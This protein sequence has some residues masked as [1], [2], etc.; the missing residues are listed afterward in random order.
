[1]SARSNPVPV[2]VL[3]R[4]G[5]LVSA[6]PV[7]VDERLTLRSLAAVLATID[8]GAALVRR[9]DGRIGIVSER[10]IA[11]A[12]AADADPDTVWSADVMTEEL[13]T[14]DADETIL[15]VALRMIDDD[16]R[17]IGV[18]KADEIIGVVSSRDI[19]QVFAESALETP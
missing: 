17:H 2:G 18:L 15:Q 14:A 11:R 10:D 8:I 16:I 3:D 6:E 7:S 19:F 13:V 4:V 12:L 1:M 5:R 9:E